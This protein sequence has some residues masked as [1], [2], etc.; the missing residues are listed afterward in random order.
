MIAGDPKVAMASHLKS[1]YAMLSR[2]LRVV[3]ISRTPERW[4]RKLQRAYYHTITRSPITSESVPDS[5]QHKTYG[6]ERAHALRAHG[7]WR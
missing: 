6:R 5:R 1:A 2:R 3:D 7:S 4:V